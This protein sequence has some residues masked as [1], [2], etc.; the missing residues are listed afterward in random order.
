MRVM[1]R[2][3]IPVEAGNRAIKDGSLARVIQATI[4]KWKPEASYFTS[5]DGRR[6]GFM[7]F[8]MVDQSQLPAFSDPLFAAF[9]ATV[10]IAPVM[11]PEDLTKGL[12]AAG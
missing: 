1:A 2:I 3:T 5:F 9:D 6:T 8:E 10:Q 11:N 4:D 7:V 12:S